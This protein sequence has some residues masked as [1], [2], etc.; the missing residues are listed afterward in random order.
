VVLSYE[1]FQGNYIKTQ[2]IHNSQKILVDNDDELRI[3]IRVIPNYELEEQILKQGE[4]VKV[5]EPKWLQDSIKERLKKA[6]EQY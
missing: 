4:R 5:V 3:S 1:A 2:P 6:L